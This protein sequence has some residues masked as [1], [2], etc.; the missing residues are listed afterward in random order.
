MGKHGIFDATFQQIILI[1][2]T[3]APDLTGPLKDLRS[4]H[5]KFFSEL[6]AS[7]SNVYKSGERTRSRC[8]NEIENLQKKHDE[9]V[10]E[11]ARLKLT[12]ISLD[13]EADDHVKLIEQLREQLKNAYEKINL[14]GG[15]AGLTPQ[16]R[17]KLSKQVTAGAE[18]DGASHINS[19]LSPDSS[20]PPALPLSPNNASHKDSSMKDVSLGG[21]N[22]QYM[23]DESASQLTGAS[24]NHGFYNG[25]V[26]G[27]LAGISRSKNWVSLFRKAVQVIDTPH[28][29]HQCK[30]PHKI[31]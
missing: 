6:Q 14:L 16:Q 15:G 11:I 1:S 27:M 22:G 29:F 25:S 20:F 7:A 31:N 4:I 30:H 5:S 3:I 26:T 23:G 9:R 24:I 12:A 19:P 17:L 8:S 18:V 21:M 13:T 10:E 28:S 2:Q